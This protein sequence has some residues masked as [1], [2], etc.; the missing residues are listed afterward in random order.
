M[1][2]Y[3][4]HQLCLLFQLY[5]LEIDRKTK[6]NK[7]PI[8]LVYIYIYISYLYTVDVNVILNVINATVG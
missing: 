1:R 6:V 7:R 5:V 4:D 3:F 8:T 2:I